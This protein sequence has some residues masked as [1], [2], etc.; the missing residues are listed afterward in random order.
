M[1]YSD[2]DDDA[3]IFAEDEELMRRG[4]DILAEWCEEWLVKVNVEKCGVMHM[5]RKGVKRTD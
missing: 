5:R 4:L 1:H 3:V 2:D